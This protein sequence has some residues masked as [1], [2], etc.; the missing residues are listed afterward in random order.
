MSDF[1]LKEQECRQDGLRR[2]QKMLDMLDGHIDALHETP[3][4][5]N[6]RPGEC[7]QALDRHIV[8]TL[9][10]LQMRQQFAQE[11][12]RADERHVLDDLLVGEGEPRMLY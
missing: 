12:Q 9:R 10:I 3:A 2:L 11:E 4:D 5:K 1:P 6:M 7:E 8:L